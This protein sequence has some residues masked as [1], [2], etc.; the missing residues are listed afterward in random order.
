M[1]M[2]TA[3]R[4]IYFFGTIGEF[5]AFLAKTANIKLSLSDWLKNQRH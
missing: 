2:L 4:C 5:R 3:S 1:K